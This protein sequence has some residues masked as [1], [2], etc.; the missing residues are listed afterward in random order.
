MLNKFYIFLLILILLIIFV[1]KNKLFEC[2]EEPNLVIPKILH[3][4][5]IGD[6]KTPENITSWTN[7]FK[8]ANPDW[9]VKVWGNK[10]IDEL[11]LVNKK[12]FNEMKEYSGKADIARYEIIYRY[13]GM[14][15]DADTFW[16]ENPIKPEF[17]KGTI[18]FFREHEHLIANGWITAV[19]NHP[20]LKL[21]I[22]EL[23]KKNISE[24]AWISV[25]PT[26]I[27]DVYN[28]IKDKE[29]YDIHFVDVKDILCP[30]SWH[31]ISNEKY[32]VLLKECQE[33]KRAFA[34]HYGLSTNHFIN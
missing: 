29:S 30:F 18:N 8:T 31:G 14:Y 17:L 5:W 24:A 9:T 25:G 22:D 28:G 7:N 6:K 34:F 19:K 12:Q 4:I 13:G 10:E 23:P 27:T 33:E 21:V 20:F 16:L 32:D 3:L 11:N 1:Y 2:F 26:L 15:I